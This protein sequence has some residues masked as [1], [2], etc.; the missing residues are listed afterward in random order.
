[1][2]HL[3]SWV[4]IKTF[5][6]WRHNRQLSP[7]DPLKALKFKNNSPVTQWLQL[8]K[9]LLLHKEFS[10]RRWRYVIFG[11]WVGHLL[12][13]SHRGHTFPKCQNWNKIFFSKWDFS[14]SVN[15]SRITTESFSFLYPSRTWY[16]VGTHKIFLICKNHENMV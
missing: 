1:M 3:A 4:K 10:R 13:K 9:T 8:F 11:S 6:T 15:T 7:C 16:K 14:N 5:S 2:S 12:A